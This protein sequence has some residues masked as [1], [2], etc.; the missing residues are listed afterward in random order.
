MKIGEKIKII[1]IVLFCVLLDIFLHMLTSPYSTMPVNPNLS[2]VAHIMGIEITASLWALLAFSVATFVFWCIR[3]EIPGEG[4]RKGLRFGI[5]IAL[6]WFLA[7]LEGISLFGNPIIK[8]IIVGLSDAIPVFL[9]GVLLSMVKTEK[10][11]GRC[12][13]AFSPTQ[14]YR[15]IILFTVVFLVGRYI[16]YSMGVIKSGIH[17]KPMETFVWTILMGITIGV[18]FILLGTYRNGKSLKHRIMGFAFLVFGMNW[19]VFL[20]FMPLLF[21]GYITDVLIR[22]VI[23]TTLV[24]VASFLAISSRKI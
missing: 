18:V 17:E 12:S 6:L 5:A 16:A 4:V 10:R 20:I 2:F 7:M 8:E 14:K 23:D 13:V 9:L 1:S 19:A 22:M 11:F 21:S 3:I 24:M 15:V